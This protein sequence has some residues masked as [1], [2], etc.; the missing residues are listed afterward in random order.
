[1]G[2]KISGWGERP[3]ADSASASAP[4]EE[5]FPDRGGRLVSVVPIPGSP[6][7]K[8]ADAIERR[9][10]VR[11]LSQI[12]TRG[13]HLEIDEVA[14]VT[15]RPKREFC[16]NLLI[17]GEKEIPFCSDDPGVMTEFIYRYLEARAE[18]DEIVTR[19]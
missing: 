14:W 10:N 12:D 7:T 19:Q 9:L 4:E 13:H 18:A 2:M 17:Q 6:L 5:N 15:M 11:L 16:F 3:E 1:M 8:L